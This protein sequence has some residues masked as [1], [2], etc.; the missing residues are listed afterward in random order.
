MK[1]F[2]L[3]A[4]DNYY[5]GEATDDWVDCFETYEEADS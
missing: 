5:P 4:G 3:T 2:L 1:Y